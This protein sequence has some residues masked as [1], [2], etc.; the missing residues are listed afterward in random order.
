MRG[1]ANFEADALSRNPIYE[2]HER[3]K[4]L[5]IVNLLTP[6][7]ASLLDLNKR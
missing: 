4:H 3:E 6:C 7:A 2:T 1:I 5:K